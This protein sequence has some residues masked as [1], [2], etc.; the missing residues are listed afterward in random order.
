LATFTA[1]YFINPESLNWGPKY[2]YIWAPSCWIAALF[3][4]FF[5]PEVKGRSLEEIDEM[6]IAR[7]P[8]RKFRKYECTGTYHMQ[9]P[10]DRYFLIRYRTC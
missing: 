7:V 10:P 3:I 5:L 4:F 1:P 9:Y 8:A 2:G 6:F